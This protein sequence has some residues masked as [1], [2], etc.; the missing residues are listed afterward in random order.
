MLIYLHDIDQKRFICKLM[1]IYQY[2]NVK[3]CILSTAYD[4]G[5]VLDE[6]GLYEV[7][8]Y[9]YRLY[10]YFETCIRNRKAG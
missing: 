6:L 5:G 1:F 2:K 7:F 9:M 4:G 8:V 10:T 3:L